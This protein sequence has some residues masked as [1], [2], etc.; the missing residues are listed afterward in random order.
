MLQGKCY[1]VTG[2]A[3]G[4]GFAV[5]RQVLA[6][7]ARVSL[8]DSGVDLRGDSP[9]GRVVDDAA[10]ALRESLQPD[11]APTHVLPLAEDV[12]NEA[13]ASCVMTTTLD[14]FGHVDGLIAAAG[15]HVEQSVLRHSDAVLDT[16]IGV[17]LRG[18]MSL[19]H[20]VA[21]HLVSRQAPG[22]VVLLCSPNAFF[23]AARQSGMAAVSGATMAFAR[24]AAVELRKHK[25]RVNALAATAKTRTTEQLPLFKGSAGTS[26]TPEH[27]AAVATFLLGDQ[28][29][30]ISGEVVGVAGSRVYAL[31]GRETAGEFFDGIPSPEALLTRWPTLVR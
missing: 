2:G 7:G 9:D 23:G 22:S 21:Q 4:I 31:R 24:S 18:T 13:G 19:T 20:Q 26:L 12:S 11:Q 1:L 14:T 8:V 5:A 28:A 25:V 29:Q 30:E 10:S 27:V 6:L 17:H 15:L 16:L 3:R